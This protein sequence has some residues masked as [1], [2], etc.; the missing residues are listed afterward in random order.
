MNPVLEA[1]ALT[2]EGILHWVYKVHDDDNLHTCTLSDE[3]AGP[4]GAGFHDRKLESALIQK[5]IRKELGFDYLID[6]VGCLHSEDPE[7]LFSTVANLRSKLRI[8]R[9]HAY[10]EIE[11]YKAFRVHGERP[12]LAVKTLSEWHNFALAILDKGFRER[13]WVE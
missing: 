13:G 8:S 5:V 2:V 11:F 9:G 6:L 3:L 10:D 7:F 4:G 1:N 12:S